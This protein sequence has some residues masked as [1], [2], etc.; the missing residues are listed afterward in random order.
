MEHSGRPPARF[1]H[2]AAVVDDYGSAVFCCVCSKLFRLVGEGDAVGDQPRCEDCAAQA[3]LRDALEHTVT[4]GE[5]RL[6]RKG[7]SAFIGT[8]RNM[9]ASRAD[10]STSGQVGAHGYLE[11][12]GNA[13]ALHE[14]VCGLRRENRELRRRLMAAQASGTPAEEEPPA[15]SG[16]DDALRRLTAVLD[17][18]IP[19]PL[20]ATQRYAQLD[21]CVLDTHVAWKDR[22]RQ[23]IALRAA[24]SAS[25]ATVATLQEELLLLEASQ[26]TLSHTVKSQQAELGQVLL[27]Q[28]AAEDSVASK[29]QAAKVALVRRAEA[30]DLLR[31]RHDGEASLRQQAREMARSL[32][33][34]HTSLDSF[35]SQQQ[36]RRARELQSRQKQLAE[37]DGQCQKVLRLI[38]LSAG[39]TRGGRGPGDQARGQAARAEL[40]AQGGGPDALRLLIEDLR[41]LM[42]ESLHHHSEVLHQLD[43]RRREV[44][45]IEREQ[46][47]LR[48][49]QLEEQLRAL[50]AARL[51][52]ESAL[53]AAF[54]QSWQ[55]Q[56]E[57]LRKQRDEAFHAREI[58]VDE[59][60]QRVV[61]EGQTVVAMRSGFAD[62]S[63]Q[64]HLALQGL[65]LTDDSLAAQHAEREGLRHRWAAHST[66]NPPSPQLSRLPCPSPC[67]SRSPLP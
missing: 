15:R 51:E 49:E 38:E 28:Q 67:P 44:D 8:L 1:V 66:P 39:D 36:A 4:A 13:Q 50:Q 47:E 55:Q 65:P 48:I 42:S 7:G 56:L 43:A 58:A 17:A 61:R 19:K 60:R 34:A 23:L 54:S 24:L 59:L 3:R 32:A 6:N 9:T 16:S 30:E 31:L 11:G 64:L 12:G 33:D 25:E 20:R 40:E 57:L 18:L 37:W 5:A 29:D 35:V 27:A 41:Q 62:A 21:A 2:S 10:S 63:E 45:G 52:A 53:S 14:I 26:V 22:N 46:Y